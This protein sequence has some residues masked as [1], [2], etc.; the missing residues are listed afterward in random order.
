[1]TLVVNFAPTQGSEDSIMSRTS[2]TGSLSAD[3][4]VYDELTL[5]NVRS[6]VVLDHGVVTVK[7]LNASL[8]NGQELGTVVVNMRSTPPT[9]SVD[10]KLQD[11]DANQLLSAIS[12]VKQTLYGLLSANADTHFT[13]TAGAQSILP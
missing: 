11:V 13:T 1:M 6:T 10:S 12:P 2:G 9:Y 5:K 3:T 4:V 8:Y 7:P